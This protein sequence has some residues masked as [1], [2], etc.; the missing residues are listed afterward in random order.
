MYQVF[1]M[2]TQTY[3]HAVICRQQ[4]YTD[5]TTHVMHMHRFTW[6]KHTSRRQLFCNFL[7]CCTAVV[8]IRAFLWITEIVKLAKVLTRIKLKKITKQFRLLQV[9]TQFTLRNGKMQLHSMMEVVHCCTQHPHTQSHTGNKYFHRPQCLMK[10]GPLLCTFLLLLQPFPPLQSLFH[11]I[12]FIFSPSLS[13]PLRPYF[14]VP[15]LSSTSLPFFN[16]FLVFL[17]TFHPFLIIISPLISLFIP[18]PL[19]SL[20]PYVLSLCLLSSYIPYF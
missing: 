6:K 2:S 16:H 11:L 7:Y 14:F 8:L 18:L 12:S 4:T 19:L 1:V 17:F 13:F 20:S 15:S 9:Y 10:G 5:T 3:E